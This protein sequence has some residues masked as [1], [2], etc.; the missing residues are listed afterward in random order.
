MP[1]AR[2]NEVLNAFINH[3]PKC[4]YT[5][6]SERGSSQSEICREGGRRGRECMVLQMNSKRLFEAM[7]EQ[8]F[9]CA[10]PMDPG[11]TYME[12]RPLPK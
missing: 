9:F 4:Q 8:G 10:L 1:E 11:R 6:D 7:Q 2:P 12:C 5:F 3:D